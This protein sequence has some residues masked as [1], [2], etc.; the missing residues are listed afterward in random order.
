MNS[1]SCGG[2]GGRFVR[3]EV[4][5]LARFI[6]SSALLVGVS[7]CH[8]SS[9]V[10]PVALPTLPSRQP[11]TA[12]ATRAPSWRQCVPVNVPF[13]DLFSINPQGPRIAKHVHFSLSSM[14]DAHDRPIE[15]ARIEHGALVR[16][17]A[18]PSL[19]GGG[20]TDLEGGQ[21]TGVKLRGVF[22]GCT[23]DPTMTFPIS[24][25]IVAATPPRKLTGA[26]EYRVEVQTSEPS[27][28]GAGPRFAPLCKE[29]KP[30]LVVPGRWDEKGVHRSEEGI[31]SFACPETVAGKCAS[32]W[33]YNP[34]AAGASPDV[35][36]LYEACMRMATAD[37]C[38]D[39]VSATR[40]GTM[41][42]VWD[43]AN[44]ERPDPEAQAQ[45][46][47]FEAAWTRDGAVCMDHPRWPELFFAEGDRKPK[48]E[49][50]TKI[51][52]CRSA[53]EAQALAGPGKKLL[54][55]ASRPRPGAPK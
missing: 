44:V 38:G 43:S 37:Y 51:P 42:D 4:S 22:D 26:W 41:V 21:W 32:S 50:L 13:A 25:K 36:E 40:E 49:C 7:G 3:A 5:A 14:Y 47:R 31:F 15:G 9:P 19:Q 55:N 12:L 17:A 16:G 11:S 8:A 35:S 24:A 28:P 6:V 33:R 34:G 18:A 10:R 53:E 1:G 54:F 2:I 23:L 39:G 20:G 29:G 48:R 46:Y 52:T 30:A 45:G 27:E